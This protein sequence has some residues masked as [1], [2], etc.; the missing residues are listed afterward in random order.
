[1]RKETA[2]QIN[3]LMLEFSQRLAGTCA[4]VKEECNVDEADAYVKPA[5]HISA[6]VFDVLDVIYLQYPDLK[7]PEFN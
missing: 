2:I 3:D 7:P 5:A 1:M 4:A 6:L